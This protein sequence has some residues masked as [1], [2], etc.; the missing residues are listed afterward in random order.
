MPESGMRIEKLARESPAPNATDT[1]ISFAH[2]VSCAILMHETDE[3]AGKKLIARNE[4]NKAA[5]QI[6]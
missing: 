4:K 5:T 1:T 2:S 3:L 6:K